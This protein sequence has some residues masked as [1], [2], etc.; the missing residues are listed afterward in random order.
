MGQWAASVLFVVLVVVGLVAFVQS[1]S[2]RV[3]VLVVR[4]PVAAGQIIQAND[5]QPA[6]VGGV[7]NAIL[8]SD[9]ESVIGQ[10]AAAGLVEGQVLTES[11]LSGTLVPAVGERLVAIR[12]EVGRVPGRLAPGD[13]VDVLVVPP[14]G[15]PGTSE[16]LDVPFKLAQSARVDSMGETPD[17]AVVLTVLVNVGEANAIAAHSAAGQVTVVQ[18]PAGE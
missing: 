7:S 2:D 10:R 17:S 3:E 16:Q 13:L 6:E 5:V 4:H 9:V 11:A 12:L 8:A 14:A 18:A 15:E 1:Q